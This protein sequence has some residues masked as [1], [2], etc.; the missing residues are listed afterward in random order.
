MAT[1]GQICNRDV[2]VAPPGTSVVEAAQLMRQ[3]HVGSL[4]VVAKDA[5]GARR[6]VGIVTDRDIVVEVIAMGLDPA[7]ITAGDIMAP[8][9]VTARESEGVLETMELMRY[10][11]VRRL[12]IVDESGQL[13]GIVAVDDLLEM[14]AEETNELVR[15]VTQERAREAQT[16]K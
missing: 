1:I 15:I 7:V 8:D 11:G 4:V 14:L 5:D 9:L 2:V 10:R 13:V 6:P 16:R 3:R 12:P